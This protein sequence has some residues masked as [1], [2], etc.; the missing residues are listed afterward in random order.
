M[1]YRFAL[2]CSSLLITPDIRGQKYPGVF[3]GP[4]SGYFNVRQFINVTIY[5]NESE[6]C[7]NL[8]FS[9]WDEIT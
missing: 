1:D 3:V 6:D 2:F 8:I 5:L 9:C 7:T 4:Q